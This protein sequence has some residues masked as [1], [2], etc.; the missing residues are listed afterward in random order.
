MEYA[1]TERDRQLIKEI[2]E[3]K[4]ARKAVVLA[5]L[6]Q[7]PEIQDLADY[8]GDSFGLSQQAATSDAEV[9]LFAGV[10]FMAESAAILSPDKRV[11]LPEPAAGCPMAE[12]VSVEGLLGLKARHPQAAVVCYVNSSAAV[13]AESDI[14]CTSANAGKVVEAVAADTVIFV[15]DRNLAHYVARTSS[16]K[17]IPWAGYCPTHDRITAEQVR[18]L[19]SEHPEALVMVHPECAPE[20]IDLADAVFSTSG[21]LSYARKQATREFIVGTEMGIIHQLRRENPGKEFYLPAGSQQI[22]PNMK[23]TN[24]EKVA[25][26]LRELE[27]VIT[28]PEEISRRAKRALD[29]ML[30]VGR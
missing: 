15:P 19:K 23:A 25:R 8:V 22:C 26:A 27:P 6:Y 14:C 5:H 9:I 7:R 21:M 28:V 11:V 13:K 18:R 2:G 12:M 16:K 24:L 20:V 1:L 4:V 17:I 10:H 3:L 29:R 30:E